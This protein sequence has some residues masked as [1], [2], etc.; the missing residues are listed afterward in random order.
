MPKRGAKLFFKSREGNWSDGEH[1]IYLEDHKSP[2][3]LK[4]AVNLERYKSYSYF[5]HAREL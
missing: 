5:M 2:A 3:S 1:E 4:M